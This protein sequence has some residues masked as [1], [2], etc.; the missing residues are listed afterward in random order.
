MPLALVLNLRNPR[1]LRI[2]MPPRPSPCLP[3]SLS[4]FFVFYVI[5]AAFLSRRRP[6]V[7]ASADC[8]CPYREAPGGEPLPFFVTASCRLPPTNLHF[9]MASLPLLTSHPFT[10]NRPVD[11]ARQLSTLSASCPGPPSLLPTAPPACPLPT[12]EASKNSVR[13]VR[14]VRQGCNLL[15]PFALRFDIGLPA[16]RHQRPHD[17]A[18]ASAPLLWRR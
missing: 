2:N 15:K 13:N 12:R 16:G 10:R 11:F 3:S 4:R 8:L 9:A 7:P 18:A 14:S 6:T 1:H 5:S 17:R